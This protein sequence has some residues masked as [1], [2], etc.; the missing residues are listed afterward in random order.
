MG[1][2]LISPKTYADLV[3]T[4]GIGGVLSLVHLVGSGTVPTIAG[5]TGAGT[6]P[7]LSISGH[8]LAGEISVTTDS[9]PS[10]NGTIVTIGFGL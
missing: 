2:F 3:T 10:A 5:G 1:A 4:S 8:D 9:N 6:S 7:T